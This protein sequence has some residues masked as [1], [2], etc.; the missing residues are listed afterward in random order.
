MLDNEGAL[1]VITRLSKQR[2]DSIEQFKKE[3]EKI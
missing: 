2:K 3:I 1:A